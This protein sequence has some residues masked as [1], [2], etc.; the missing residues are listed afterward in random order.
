MIRAI[1]A[2]GLLAT[3]SAL[4]AIAVAALAFFAAAFAAAFAWLAIAV[5]ALIGI[6][7]TLAV[8][9]LLGIGVVEFALLG[10]PLLA[11]LRWAFS[12]LAG[13]G[14]GW[15]RGPLVLALG[16]SGHTRATSWDTAEAFLLRWG[17]GRGRTRRWLVFLRNRLGT[18]RF[19]SGRGSNR[20]A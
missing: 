2:M 11:F 7:A 19:W 5:L 12:L 6:L 3:A 14:L 10:M 1:S 8:L 16:F 13:C 18:W 17:W 15:M 9:V 4:L 20:W